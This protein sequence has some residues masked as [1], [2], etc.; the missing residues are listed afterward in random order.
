MT[1]VRLPRRCAPRN[2]H[3]A[4]SVKGGTGSGEMDF[5]FGPSTRL[6]LAQDDAGRQFKKNRLFDS[7]MARSGPQGPLRGWRCASISDWGGG[8]GGL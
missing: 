2:D 6:R 3:R 4:G 8:R 5:R 7:A 1:C